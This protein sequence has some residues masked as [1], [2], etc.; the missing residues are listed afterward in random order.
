M[1]KM[2]FLVFTTLFLIAPGATCPAMEQT[3]VIDVLQVSDIEVYDQAYQGFVQELAKDGLVAGTNLTVNRRV[4]PFDEEK[5]GMMDRLKLRFSTVGR[6]AKRIVASKPDLVLTMGTPATLYGKDRFTAAGIPVVFTA[7]AIPQ[8]AGCRS[9]NEAGPGFTGSTL[10]LDMNY[11]LKIVTLSFPR[12]RTAGII[13]SDD[14]NGSSQAKEAQDKARG[15]GLKVIVRKVKKTQDIRPV[16][17]DLVRQGVELF[18]LPLDTY[19]GLN[20]NQQAKELAQVSL[21]T[22]VP[23]VSLALSRMP[24]AVLYVGSD[25]KTVG[26]MSGRQA[27]KI[28]KKATVVDR[29]PVLRMDQ[30][31]V[32]KDAE[33]M[34][35][36]GVELP[37]Q[38]LK[39]AHDI[40]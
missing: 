19:Y 22:K 40:Q 9:L 3:F 36:L 4:I 12:V 17:E 5:S 25:F 16:A 38:I 29:M 7:V 26:A 37:D 8:A 1:K 6:E 32:M 15:F 20:G 31:N 33:A 35:A 2:R 27:A 30:L 11:V 18:I 23:V 28:L 21:T 13:H 34:K 39:V 24:G 14:E 10:Y